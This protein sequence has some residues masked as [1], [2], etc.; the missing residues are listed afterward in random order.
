[1]KIKTFLGAAAFAI[2]AM[3]TAASA[4]H[5]SHDGPMDLV[6][7]ACDRYGSGLAVYDVCFTGGD[8][9]VQGHY[10]SLACKDPYKGTRFVWKK[11]FLG[12]G[13]YV[14]TCTYN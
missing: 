7:P 4:G 12:K 1:M 6:T 3:A 5:Q 9:Y 8:P 10:S 11:P 14:L 2:S 13:R